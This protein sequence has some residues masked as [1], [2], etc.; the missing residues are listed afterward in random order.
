MIKL[1]FDEL[2]R[3]TQDSMTFIAGKIKAITQYTDKWA[4]FHEALYQAGGM[5]ALYVTGTPYKHNWQR[6]ARF[7]V[8][9]WIAV[10]KTFELYNA[11][12]KIA[13]APLV[14]GS[15]RP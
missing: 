5:E 3:A 8:E 2:P 1:S 12:N 4:H 10:L 15:I 11:E 9:V 13:L 6:P 14:L 7:G